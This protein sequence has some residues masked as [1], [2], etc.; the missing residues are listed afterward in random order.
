MIKFDAN[1]LISRWYLR[2]KL[3]IRDIMVKTSAI[4]FAI[5]FKLF[6]SHSSSSKCRRANSN[7]T[8]YKWASSLAWDCIFIYC[9]S[10]IVLEALSASFPEK[11][12]SRNDTKTR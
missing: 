3:T 5:I 12:L 1:S 9:N 11:S 4:L 7:T 8:C 6:F 10:S 2:V